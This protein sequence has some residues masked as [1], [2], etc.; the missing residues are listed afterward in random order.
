MGVPVVDA[1]CEAEA[2]CAELAKAG[3]VWATATEDMDALTF[4]TPKLIRKLTMS[5]TSKDKK[6]PII[7]IDCE[8]VLS[9]MGLSYEQF[10]DLCIMCGCDYTNTI[11]GIGPKNALKLIREFKNIEAVLVHL[12]KGKKHDIPA[13]WKEQRVSKKALELAEKVVEEA[14]LAREAKE[15]EDQRV[16]LA[17]ALL[18]APTVQGFDAGSDGN[19]YGGAASNSGEASAPVDADAAAAGGADFEEGDGVGDAAHGDDD[20]AAEEDNDASPSGIS[21]GEYKGEKQHAAVVEEEEEIDA[22]DLEIIP[23]QFQQAR[24][25]FITADVTPSSMIELK[26]TEPDIEGLKDYIKIYLSTQPRPIITR[27]TMKSVEEKFAT[28]PFMRVHKSYIVSLNKIESIRNL[29]ISIGTHLIPVSE[30]FSDELL[31]RIGSK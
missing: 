6:Q 3:H 10:V 20:D 1:P 7:E 21:S 2:Q 28:M 18:Q 5:Q 8:K 13:D 12:E 17:E 22:D 30:Q 25:L 16:R 23:P 29:K 4:R 24:G 27:M 9:G 11:K 26:W 15:A 19:A 31:R 14:R